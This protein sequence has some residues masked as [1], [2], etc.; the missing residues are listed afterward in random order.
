MDG[1]YPAMVFILEWVWV[2]MGLAIMWLFTKYLA[3]GREVTA[4]DKNVS[5]RRASINTK[6][7]V[8]EAQQN[9]LKENFEEFT[10]RNEKAHERLESK[11][12]SHNQLVMK[13]FD[14][15]T[16]LIRNGNK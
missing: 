12:D 9:S 15:L 4:L 8:F 14:S 11:M 16:G 3:L 5:E 1:Q 7:A 10:E 6:L 2:P 13:R